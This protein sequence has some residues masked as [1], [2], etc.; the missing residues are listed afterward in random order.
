MSVAVFRC[1]ELWEQEFLGHHLQLYDLLTDHT[2]STYVLLIYNFQIPL[3][4]CRIPMC[5][6]EFVYKI[7]EGS[8]F[9]ILTHREDNLQDTSSNVCLSF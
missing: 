4:I 3:E 6:L 2:P 8:L 1:Y 9:S 7:V 5:S